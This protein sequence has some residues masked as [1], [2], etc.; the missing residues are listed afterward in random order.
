MIER[1]AHQRLSE[2]IED[3]LGLINNIA[4]GKAREDQKSGS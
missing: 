1:R 2:L 4:V 3:T